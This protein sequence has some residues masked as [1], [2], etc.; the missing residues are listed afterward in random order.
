MKKRFFIFIFFFVSHL[1]ASSLLQQTVHLS[2][3]ETHFLIGYAAIQQKRWQ[4]AERH[5]FQISEE[6]LKMVEEDVLF[7]RAVSNFHLGRYPKAREMF[8]ELLRAHSDSL[9]IPESRMYLVR[10]LI[11]LGLLEDARKQADGLVRHRKASPEFREADLL[12]IEAAIDMGDG[13]AAAER[14]RT[15]ALFARN[16]KELQELKPLMA[17]IKSLT[18]EDIDSWLRE[19]KQQFLLGRS[20]EEYGGW[21][22]ASHRYRAVVQSSNVSGDLLAETKWRLGECLARL[23]SYGEATRLLEEVRM[24]PESE[25]FR[26]QLLSVLARTYTKANRYTEAAKVL[27][28]LFEG[29]KDRSLYWYKLAFL[30][31]D[32]GHFEEASQQFD[33]LLKKNPKQPMAA[34]IR[35]KLFWCLKK[36]GRHEEA[37]ATLRPIKL[38]KG[39]GDRVKYW[40]ARTL[41]RLGRESEAKQLYEAFANENDGDYYSQLA[42]FRV[43]KNTEDAFQVSAGDRHGARR[44]PRDDTALILRQAQDERPK[45]HP[46]QGTNS[47]HFQRALF[48]DRLGLSREVRQSLERASMDNGVPKQNIAELALRHDG[49]YLVYQLA[50]KNG[51][52]PEWNEMR[53]PRAF[54]REVQRALGSSRFDPEIV[55]ALMAAE[56]TY[57]P[58]VVSSVGAIGLMQLMP[59]TAARYDQDKRFD[60]R[61]LFL[62][63]VNIRLGVRYLLHLHRLFPKNL[64]AVL[65][66]YNAGEP[67]VRRW[68]DK[69]PK[70]DID[71]FIEEIPYA[72][73][74]G[75]VKK[76]M[77]EYWIRG[78]LDRRNASKK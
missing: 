47:Y 42:G 69:N 65:A 43:S 78:T 38:R 40:E 52:A 36:L 6:T 32:Q 22:E 27:E 19:P 1:E 13:K 66:S 15:I 61:Q 60:A 54:E 17:R 68:I 55:Y 58:W 33:R 74:Q 18:G 59:S 26:E 46:E 24:M 67:A 9:F 2:S 5:F 39:E 50:R 49:Y 53:Y 63:Q 10:T 25:S 3:D 14:L 73:T 71:E 35:W 57:R 41:E 21:K 48:F 45:N 7:H 51:D 62:P 31:M 70:S 29:K 4:E 72:E 16:E 77:A 23:Q 64:A 28:L 11:K 76:I 75:Y 8:E 12:W 44:A 20:F 34:D 56:S 37:L 30:E